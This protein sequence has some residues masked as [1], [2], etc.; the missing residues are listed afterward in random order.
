VQVRSEGKKTEVGGGLD[1]LCRL[2]RPLTACRSCKCSRRCSARLSKDDLYATGRM[3]NL[4]KYSTDPAAL[5]PAHSAKEYAIPTA[6]VTPLPGL[7]GNVA[8]GRQVHMESAARALARRLHLRVT[9]ARQCGNRQQTHAH[10]GTDSY[11][12]RILSVIVP[13]SGC[14]RRIRRWFAL[15]RYAQTSLANS[16]SA[17]VLTRVV[18]RGPSVLR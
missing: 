5:P 17:H 15:Q 12:G 6:Q 10:F 2:S 8:L 13:H 1:L 7:R 11:R 4:V 14:H 9:H 3:L 18:M 16:K